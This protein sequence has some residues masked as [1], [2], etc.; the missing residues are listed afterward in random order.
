L[1]SRT[2]IKEDSGTNWADNQEQRVNSIRSGVSLTHQ[3]TISIINLLW[4]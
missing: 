2:K 4:M 1:I 3:L